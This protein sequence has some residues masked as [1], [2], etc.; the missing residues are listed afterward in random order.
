MIDVILNFFQ[1]LEKSGAHK[2]I[3]YYILL[4][5]W[6]FLYYTVHDY[7]LY[8]Y[9]PNTRAFLVD[10]RTLPQFIKHSYGKFD[11]VSQMSAMLRHS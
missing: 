11:Q 1:I 5:W 7:G 4:M 10:S 2:K 8:L 9:R 6:Q 3:N